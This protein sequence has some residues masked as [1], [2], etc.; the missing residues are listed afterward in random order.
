MS[1]LHF[2]QKLTRGAWLRLKTALANPYSDLG[3]SSITVKKIKH[4]AA[5]KERK[6]TVNGHSLYYQSPTELI[7]GLNEIFLE[8]VYEQNFGPKP[9]IIDCG[10]NIGLSVI[11]FKQIAPDAIIEA[12]EPDIQNYT[13]LKKNV[14]SF[15]LQQVNLHNKAIWKEEKV[16]KFEADGQMS[17]KIGNE[18]SGEKKMVDVDAVRLKDK[19]TRTVDFLKIDIEG[20]EYEVLNDAKEN[21]SNVKSMFFEYHGTYAQNNQLVE[22]L[23]IIREAGFS[24][25]IKEA[26]SIFD[27]PLNGLKRFPVDWDVQLNIFCV[28]Q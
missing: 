14:T 8:K 2:L 12:Y 23:S 7:H 16:L 11:Y 4:Q 3:L 26:T 9:Y 22:L 5:D 24:F 17:S 25:Y 10:A 15:G 13:L 27:S 1:K 20:A 28:R 18:L 6:T 21:L 19:L